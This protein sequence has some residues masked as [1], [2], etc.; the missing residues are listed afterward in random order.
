MPTV[1][2]MNPVELRFRALVV[3]DNPADAMLLEAEL[4]RNRDAQFEITHVERLEDAL[5]SLAVAS[6]DLCCWTSVCPTLKVR[7][8]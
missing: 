2:I 1:E 3:E 7:T 6:Y 4:S 8:L 5:A